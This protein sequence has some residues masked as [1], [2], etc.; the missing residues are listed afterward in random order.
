[1]MRA[2]DLCRR[3]GE[4]P[5]LFPAKLGVWAYYLVRSEQ[6]AARELAEEMLRMAEEAQDSI[7]LAGAHGCLGASLTHMADHTAGL[8][9]L[10][11]AT[12]L[13][14]PQ[15]RQSY[16]LLYG[17]DLG[18]YWGCEIE[19]TLWILGYP[20][21]ARLQ[22]GQMLDLAREGAEPLPTAFALTYAAILHQ[23]CREAEQ[24]QED[25][26]VLIALCDEHGISGHREWGMC[27]RGWALAEQGLVDDGVAVMREH[28][29]A[30]RAKGMLVEVP[31][32]LAGLAETL[33]KWGRTH[34]GLAAVTMALD[35]A[36]STNQPVYM[37]EYLRLKGELLAKGKGSPT[38]AEACLHEALTIAGGQQAKSL[39]LRAA[40]SMARLWQRQGKKDD[41]RALLAPVYDWFSEGFETVDMRA[42]KALLEALS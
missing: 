16:R 5:E 31:Y 34:E 39:E 11:S 6:Q 38:E 33:E 24:A 2:R 22:M 9:H 21:R 10:Q 14:D 27:I 12:E 41:A 4:P 35:I 15:Q 30:L 29:D 23:L 7:W 37:A 17:Q 8:A 19:R 42:A 32:F 18:V 13:Y 1:M 36:S 28:T 3:L 25:A 20:E 26:D 40:M